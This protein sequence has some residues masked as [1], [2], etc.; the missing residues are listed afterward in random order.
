MSLFSFIYI[1][2]IYYILQYIFF[3]KFLS[4]GHKTP[5]RRSPTATRSRTQRR[6]RVPSPVAVFMCDLWRTLWSLYHH[7]R[8]SLWSLYGVDEIATSATL[9][10][11]TCVTWWHGSTEFWLWM[12]L[13]VSDPNAVLPQG[14][15]QNG[16]SSLSK[17][18]SCQDPST[19]SELTYR[20]KL[21]E[22]E[23]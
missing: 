23:C 2:H 11:P 1:L 19:N 10:S 15:I 18:N 22:T 3:A 17:E 14:A 13:D 12:S 16:P 5:T 9:L 20:L 8:T 21:I 6:G 4:L 7:S